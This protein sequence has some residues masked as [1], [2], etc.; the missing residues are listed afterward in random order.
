MKNI[1]ILCFFIIYMAHGN[2]KLEELI[3]YNEK[4]A[5][6]YKETG[7]GMIGGKYNLEFDKLINF[8][9]GSC[10]QQAYLLARKAKQLG[11]YAQ[12][13]GLFAINGANDVMVTIKNKNIHYLFVP[14]TGAYFKNSLWEILE[15]PS[16]ATNYIAS[17]ASNSH[18]L[19]ARSLFLSNSFFSTLEK[20]E[21]NQLNKYE[22]N[23][24]RL[25]ELSGSQNLYP[26]PYNEKHL[27]DNQNKYYTAGKENKKLQSVTYNFLQK[28]QIYRFYFQWYSTQDYAKRI[29][30]RINDKQT[31]EYENS[32]N[33]LETEIVLPESI[34][35]VQK[36]EFI[37]SDFNGQNRL[38]LKQL[39]AY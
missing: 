21:F 25:A 6:L 7:P 19:N 8:S 36:I 35:E 13:I 15:Y 14:S 27:L 29:R 18:V 38:L 23:I 2:D 12:Q 31:L 10:T 16:L 11:F 32:E 5:T 33:I 9:N 24:L 34:K 30:I 28:V 39:G 1:L 37:F 26:E 17:E 22:T 3:K 20:I 4:L